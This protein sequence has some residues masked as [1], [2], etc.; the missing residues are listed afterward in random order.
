MEL[1]HSVWHASP[2]SQLSWKRTSSATGSCQLPRPKTPDALPDQCLARSLPEDSIIYIVIQLNTNTNMPKSSCC[3][4]IV[5]KAVFAKAVVEKAVVAPAA[6]AIKLAESQKAPQTETIT[7]G[8]KAGTITQVRTLLSCL[9]LRSESAPHP[10]T[11]L[12]SALQECS[13]PEDPSFRSPCFLSPVGRS[14]AQVQLGRSLKTP[15]DIFG[16]AS[17]GGQEGI[18][19]A[20]HQE[21]LGGGA[22]SSLLHYLSASSGVGD[23][24]ADCLKLVSRVVVSPP[25]EVSG[26]REAL[27]FAKAAFEK[28]VVAPVALAIKL[29][30]RQI[31]QGQKHKDTAFLLARAQLSS[32]IVNR[33]GGRFLPEPCSEP[34]LVPALSLSYCP[35]VLVPARLSYCPAVPALSPCLA[36][37]S[38]SAPHPRTTLSS[39]LQECSS[40]ED[41]SFRSPC[42]LSPVGRSTAQVQVGRSPKTPFGI[43]GA[44]SQ[45]EQE[46]IDGARH[47]ESSLGEQAAPCCTTCL[48]PR[49]QESR[50]NNTSPNPALSTCSEP[51][52][53]PKASC[54]ALR[55][56]SAR[57]PH[58]RTTLYSLLQEFSSPEDPSFRSPCFLSP[59]ARSTAQAAPQRRHSASSERQVRADKKALIGQGIMSLR[60]GSWQ[61]PITLLVRFPR[62][63]DP[64]EACHTERGRSIPCTSNRDNNTRTESRDNNTSPNPALSICSEP[65]LV[66]ALSLSYCP[67][68][69]VP[70]RL[71]YCPA[72]PALSPCLALR[73]ESAPHPRTTLSSALQECSSPEDPSFRSPCFLSPVGR[74]TAQVQVGRSTAQFFILPSCRYQRPPLASLVRQVRADMEGI[75]RASIRK[76]IGRLGLA[77]PARD[78]AD[79]LKP[80]SR[81][82]V[83][84]PG[85]VSGVRAALVVK[86]LSFWHVCV[87]VQLYYYVYDGVSKNSSS[88]VFAE[89]VVEKAI[90]APALAIKLA[91][92]KHSNGDNNKKDIKRDNNTSPNPALS[93]CSK[94]VSLLRACLTARLSLLCLPALSPCSEPA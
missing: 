40:P 24:S 1:P 64:S 52:S 70:A 75:D 6:L 5:I 11:T 82:A 71:S 59:I 56:E 73:S 91:E 29:A 35:T 77:A 85:E 21:S 22:G 39:A 25:E 61:L 49:E 26:V 32:E 33:R 46:G 88:V 41:P 65:V 17:Q 47:H 34:V 78:C 4:I 74:S 57:A 12:Y 44:A 23:N 51:V 18:D 90:V 60:W 3:Y 50:E 89:A 9:A 19:R 31:T 37:R 54:L 27:A 43:F 62:S 93:T 53:L 16:A 69:L 7:Q 20:R 42:F 80:V 83:S 55:F 87:G 68:V 66:P 81:V 15:F 2:G 58:P 30:S 28:A 8:Q 76:S 45:G 84:P 38:E 63:C 94:P 72:V 67:T 79:C 13:S 92:R 36:L 86:Y 14:T 10:R 48:L